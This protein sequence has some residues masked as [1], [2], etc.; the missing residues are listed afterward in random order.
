MGVAA[1][2][3]VQLAFPLDRTDPPDAVHADDIAR[4]AAEV[5]RHRGQHRARRGYAQAPWSAGSWKP[6]RRPCGRPGAV[7]RAQAGR[8]RP[9]WS[10]W[11]R[12]L[13]ELPGRRAC[14]R[15]SANP[16]ADRA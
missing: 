3:R 16:A 5:L 4:H 13:S 9:Y 2:A 14:V 11:A 1:R 7:T 12:T 10:I 6:W 15:V 8:E